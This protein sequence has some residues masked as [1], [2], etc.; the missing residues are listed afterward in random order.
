MTANPNGSGPTGGPGGKT[1][2]PWE[3]AP[4]SEMAAQAAAPSPTEAAPW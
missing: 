3:K 2:L 4:A 1:R